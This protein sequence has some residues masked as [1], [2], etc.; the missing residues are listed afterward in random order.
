MMA[1]V[2]PPEV[3]TRDGFVLRPQDIPDRF[4]PHSDTWFFSRVAGTFNERQG[5][6]GCQMPEQLLGR[7]IRACSNEGDL[8]LDPF[9]GS[10]TTP[11][12]ARKLGRRYLGLELSEDYVACINQRL[13]ASSPGDP[14]TGPQDAVTSAPATHAG[15]ARRL[16]A[17]AGMTHA[18]G[19]DR[20]NNGTR[21][22][23]GRTSKSRAELP[24]LFD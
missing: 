2:L 16:E 19:N 3:P 4:P 20:P 12:V 6:H 7:I 10:G 21:R 13:D 1:P 15:R 8:V 9:A 22:R 11:A 17:R 24:F 18:G 14:L 23:N 5:F